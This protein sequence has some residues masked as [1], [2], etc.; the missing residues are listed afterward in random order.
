M[1]TDRDELGVIRVEN[2]IISQGNVPTPIAD[3][4]SDHGD[5]DQSALQM[6]MQDNP[7]SSDSQA[8]VDYL[9]M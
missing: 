3:E 2:M 4:D 5:L 8:A 1:S 9:N 6:L 7:I